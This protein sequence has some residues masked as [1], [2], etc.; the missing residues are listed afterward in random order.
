MDIYAQACNFSI[1]P[2]VGPM[3]ADRRG[4]WKLHAVKRQID[5]GDRRQ[6]V[7]MEMVLASKVIAYART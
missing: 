4:L 2:R 5:T 1:A 6:Q 3:Y 7:D